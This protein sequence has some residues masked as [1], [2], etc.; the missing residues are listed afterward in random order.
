MIDAYNKDSDIHSITA[1][2]VFDVS[3]DEVTDLMRRKA[4]AVNFGIIYGISSFGLGQDLDISR[5]EAEGYIEKYFR[6]YGKVKEF[7]DKCVSDAKETGYSLTLFNR[8]RPIPELK[9][10]N[11]M[12]RSFGERVAMNAPI[13]GTAADII[14]IAMIRVNNELKEKKLKSRLVLQVHDELIIETKLEELEEV[15]TILV[16]QMMNAAK[17]LVS[18][19]VDVNEG[20]SWYDAK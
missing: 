10:S 13:Q 11:Y 4:K 9:S 17:L 19:V 2:E 14:K 7:M 16:N 6:T 12:V 15:K 8:R 5:K 18:L 1:S 20:Y 3:L